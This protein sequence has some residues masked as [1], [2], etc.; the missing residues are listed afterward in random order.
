MKTVI[1]E[2]SAPETTVD[3]PHCDNN[4]IEIEPDEYGLD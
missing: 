3:C 4:N 1:A 2:T